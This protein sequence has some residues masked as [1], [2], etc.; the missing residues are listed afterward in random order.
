MIIDE[1]LISI[2]EIYKIKKNILEAEFLSGWYFR[3]NFLYD[4]FIYAYD[5]L[6][7]TP[8]RS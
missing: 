1:I 8:S 3:A 6:D 4:F 7:W 2:L 5:A